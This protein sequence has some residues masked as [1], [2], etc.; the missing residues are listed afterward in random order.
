MIVPA[1]EYMLE[2]RYR[3]KPL[4]GLPLVVNLQPGAFLFIAIIK[5]VSML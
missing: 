5:Q 2:G 1:N 4:L 3:I